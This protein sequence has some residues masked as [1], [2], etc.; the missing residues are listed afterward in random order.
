VNDWYAVAVLVGAMVLICVLD[1]LMRLEDRRAERADRAASH[2]R[3]M[4]EIR[5]QG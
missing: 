5:R 1:G 2:D 3:L 4:D